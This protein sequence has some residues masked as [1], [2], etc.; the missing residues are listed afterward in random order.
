MDDIMDDL[1]GRTKVLS[2]DGSG[3]RLLD[4]ALLTHQG[5]RITAY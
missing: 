1:D 3:A 2:E 5:M 4:F